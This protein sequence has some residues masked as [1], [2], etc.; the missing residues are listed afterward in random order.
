MSSIADTECE[1]RNLTRSNGLIQRRAKVPFISQN[2]GLLQSSQNPIYEMGRSIPPFERP[3]FTYTVCSPAFSSN[4]LSSSLGPPAR[5]ANGFLKPPV[6]F[7]S[8]SNP[9][10]MAEG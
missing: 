10:L 3:F 4:P 2:P 9:V 7:P 6:S 1:R 8:N 5:S